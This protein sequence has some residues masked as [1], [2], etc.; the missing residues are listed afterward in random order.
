MYNLRTLWVWLWGDETGSD[1]GNSIRQWGQRQWPK[2]VEKK[3]CWYI[4]HRV[5]YYPILCYLDKCSIRSS[6]FWTFSRVCCIEAQ[7]KM[8]I[9]FVYIETIEEKRLIF[10]CGQY[11][12]EIRIV[13]AYS[14]K[15][16]LSSVDT[17]TE[18]HRDP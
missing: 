15:D 14:E 2:M 1:R 10:M 12:S 4:D 16:I 13:K 18:N 17:V 11:G 9:L 3:S 8:N 5:I 6:T 7:Y